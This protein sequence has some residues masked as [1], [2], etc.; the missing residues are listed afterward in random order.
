VK[1]VAYTAVIG[2]YDQPREPSVISDGW[3]YILYTDL[4]IKSDVWEVVKVGSGRTPREN[5]Y[6]ARM[7]KIL[8][9]E[10]VDAR[11][12]LWV[13]ANIQINCDLNEFSKKH[14]S[15]WVTMSH[16]RRKGIYQESKACQHATEQKLIKAQ[17]EQYRSE[18]YF[19][20]NGLISSGILLRKNR[21]N[22]REFC[23]K[24][25]GEIDKYSIR[26]QLSFNY[27]LWKHPLD[28]ELIPYNELMSNEFDI[29]AH[30][31]WKS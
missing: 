1:K 27:V 26:D 20:D 7:I 18:Y 4:D 5:I 31:R 2:S 21:K 8:F 9:H 17:M 12:S 23:E 22:V 13:D 15:E 29:K 24:W 16:P 14:T 3:R 19:A 10:F 6:I 11:L 25:F 28:L 30:K